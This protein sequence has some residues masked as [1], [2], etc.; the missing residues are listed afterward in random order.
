M[1]ESKGAIEIP[2]LRYRPKRE[3]VAAERN[4]NNWEKRRK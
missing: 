1:N 2:E 3:K 4:V